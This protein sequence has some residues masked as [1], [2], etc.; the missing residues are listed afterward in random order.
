MLNNVKSSGIP[1]SYESMTTLLKD[2][3]QNLKGIKPSTY[4]TPCGKG[5]TSGLVN[6]LDNLDGSWGSAVKDVMNSQCGGERNLV[7]CALDIRAD[8]TVHQL[9]GPMEVLQT[10]SETEPRLPPK[11]RLFQ[12]APRMAQQALLLPA[13]EHSHQMARVQ[14]TNFKA[15]LLQR[16]GS[17]F[18]LAPSL[19][20]D[21]RAYAGRKVHNSFRFDTRLQLRSLCT[22]TIS[23]I[24]TETCKIEHVL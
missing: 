18:W 11:E 2:P 5:S 9:A 19:L 20:W 13:K 16:L 23:L 17:C 3:M 8:V 24:S 10:L 22:L 14:H 1:I 21:S 12:A 7:C 6:V 4:C 15:P